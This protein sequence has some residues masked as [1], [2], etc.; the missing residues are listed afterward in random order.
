MVSTSREV[1]CPSHGFVLAPWHSAAIPKYA[2]TKIKKRTAFLRNIALII[3]AV[4]GE[5]C[6][7]SKKE[8]N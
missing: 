8:A 5:V 4:G 2:K 7:L 3:P 1:S 6:R